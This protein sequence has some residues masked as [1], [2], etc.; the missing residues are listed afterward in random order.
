MAEEDLTDNPMLAHKTN[1]QLA[2]QAAHGGLNLHP[3]QTKFAPPQIKFA[4][5]Q[6][7]FTPT[8]PSYNIHLEL[9]ENDVEYNTKESSFSLPKGGALP[10]RHAVLHLQGCL[11]LI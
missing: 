8:A 7:K 5:P 3:P 6:T 1:Q 10:Q 4:P 11:L 9:K 2:R